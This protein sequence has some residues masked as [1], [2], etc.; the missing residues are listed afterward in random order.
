MTKKEKKD[1]EKWRKKRN[2]RN[3]RLTDMQVFN[4]KRDR[5]CSLIKVCLKRKFKRILVKD[6]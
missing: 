5:R 4:M 6:S 1:T 2:R 3:S